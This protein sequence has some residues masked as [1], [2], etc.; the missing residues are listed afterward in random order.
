MFCCNDCGNFF[1]V[2]SNQKIV[3]PS[4]GSVN[5]YDEEDEYYYD[6]DE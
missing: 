1:E 3:C 4:C 6:D 5:V 2:R